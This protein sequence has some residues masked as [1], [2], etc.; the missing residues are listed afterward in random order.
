MLSRDDLPGRSA[1]MEH[2]NYRKDPITRASGRIIALPTAPPRDRRRIRPLN[3]HG[4]RSIPNKAAYISRS[5]HDRL[6]DRPAWQGAEKLK[7]PKPRRDP[8]STPCEK[9]GSVFSFGREHSDESS[10]VIRLFHQPASYSE[11]S[12]PETAPETM[13]EQQ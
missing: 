9:I 5:F 7:I 13:E 11:Q 8:H 4:A 10:L 2:C 12:R 1:P 6:L 3:E